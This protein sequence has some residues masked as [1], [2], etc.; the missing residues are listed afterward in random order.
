MLNLTKWISYVHQLDD[1]CFL[2]NI[3]WRLFQSREGDILFTHPPND[4][5]HGMAYW[6][7]QSS[8][9]GLNPRDQRNVIFLGPIKIGYLYDIDTKGAHNQSYVIARASSGINDRLQYGSNCWQMLH[10]ICAVF[11]LIV[12]LVL[13]C[14]Q[15]V[16]STSYLIEAFLHHIWTLHW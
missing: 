6:T 2:R 13:V 15:I 14:N 7:P 3:K 4:Q 16:L 9:F 1:K 10:L 11:T 8:E 5:K 12:E